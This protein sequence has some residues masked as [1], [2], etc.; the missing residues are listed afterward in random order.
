MNPKI[1]AAARRTGQL[2]LSNRG[3]VAV[4]E[5]VWSIMEPTEEEVKKQSAGASI[6]GPDQDSWWDYQDLTKLILACNKISLLSDKI[7]NLVSLTTLDLHDNQ[8]E[9]IPDAISNLENLTKLNI[10]HNRLKIIPP[11][12]FDLK[13]LRT[14][15]MSNNELESVGEHISELNMLISLDLSN[16]NI[17][18][19]HSNIGY[20]TQVQSL[21]LS[22]N[23]LESLPNE[24]DFMQALQTLDLTSNKMKLVTLKDLGHL[25][26]LY[27]RYNQLT[28]LPNLV[29]CISLKELQMGNNFLTTIS[30]QDLDSIKNVKILE[31]RENKI[32]SLPDTIDTLAQLERLDL[33]RND[34][35]T[36][37]FTLGLLPMLK[38]LQ[39]DGNPMKTIRRDIISRGTVGLLKYLRSRLD[40]DTLSELQSEGRGNTSPLPGS[41]TPPLP[42][43]FT[44]GTTKA[45]VLASKDLSDIPTETILE[46]VD[47]GVNGVNAS[48]NQFS[49]IPEAIQPLLPQLTELDFSQNKIVEI[50]AW[51]GVSQRLLYLN[52]SKNKLRKIPEEIGECKILREIDLSLNALSEIPAGLY[53]CKQLESIRLGSNSVSSIPAVQLQSLPMLAVLDLQNNAVSQVPPELGNVTQLRSLLLEGNLFRVPRPNILAQ[54]TNAILAYLRDRIPT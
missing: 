16:N 7:S 13:E 4:P 36:L 15:S 14:L 27:L 31:L 34:L 35:T 42:D 25:E 32:A 49:S 48:K 5:K 39:V 33:S 30:S 46:A 2:N 51:I 45:L 44:M 41:S 50:S 1:L 10:S 9:T 20:L 24:I 37:P 52:L 53:E 54:G 18:T 8:L 47:A 38:S 6:D 29:N 17:T 3:L 28:T 19:L 43:K 22:K 11:G 40:S 12:V 21:L 26:L 23:K